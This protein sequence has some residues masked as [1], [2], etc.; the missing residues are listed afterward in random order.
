MGW[1][2]EEVSRA[3]TFHIPPDLHPGRRLPCLN[4]TPKP[5]RGAAPPSAQLF[6]LGGGVGGWGWGGGAEGTHGEQF[7]SHQS[8]A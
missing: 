1:R 3:V 6:P 4:A 5:P 8:P 2:G 7:R